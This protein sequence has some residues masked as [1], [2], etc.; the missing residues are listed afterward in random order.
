[1]AQ[2]GTA[3]FLQP[4]L[5]AAQQFA[6]RPPIALAYSVQE[7]IHTRGLKIRS[8]HVFFHNG[9]IL[10]GLS[11]RTQADSCPVWCFSSLREVGG[12]YLTGGKIQAGNGL[13]E[14]C[15]VRQEKEQR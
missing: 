8:I 10:P 12:E 5:D 2:H 14:G 6:L 11:P 1:M 3:D 4:P 7:Q 9:A 13:E 15:H